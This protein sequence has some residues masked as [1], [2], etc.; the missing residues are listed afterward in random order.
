MGSVALER[1]QA[2][3]MTEISVFELELNVG[4]YLIAKSFEQIDSV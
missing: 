2:R 4:S 3:R 1:K